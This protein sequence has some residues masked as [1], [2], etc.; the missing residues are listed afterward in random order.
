MTKKF[1]IK[2]ETRKRCKIIV[3][4]AENRAHFRQVSLEHFSYLRE[5]KSI[6]FSL[7]IRVDDEIIEFIRPA[8]FSL[9]LLDQ[10]WNSSLKEDA[11]IDVFVLKKEYARFSYSLSKVRQ[12]KISLLLEKDPSLDRKTLETFANLSEASQMILRGGITQSVVEHVKGS[13]AFMVK[14]LM[15]NELAM[16]TLSRM[17][18]IDPT[19]YDHSASVAM[20]STI[21]AKQY[22]NPQLSIREAEVIAQCGLYHDTGKSCLP[23]AILNKPGSFTGGEYEIMKTHVEHG[24]RELMQ[25]IDS[26]A[27]ID[28][29]VALVAIEHH[30]RFHGHG[31]PKGK[32]GRAEEDPQNGIH[33][34]SRIVSIADAYS[35]LLMKRVYKPALAAENAIEL[36]KQSAPKDFDLEIF[37]PFIRGVEGSLRSLEDRRKK[38]QL[39]KIY[40]SDSEV[41]VLDQIKSQQQ[42]EPELLK[43]K[44]S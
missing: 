31:Y 21:M 30:E 6:D 5:L 3:A 24:H 42:L 35:A 33:I 28:Q 41:T 39:G 16:S 9:V 8:E 10:I 27:P 37:E 44:A 11:E 32:R 2:E 15:D 40:F 23:H 18:T 13:A 14:Q 20:F 1:A 36:M 29:L 26:G 17:V 25:V 43:T 7:F 19:L 22:V 4:K 12:K 38:M 34:F